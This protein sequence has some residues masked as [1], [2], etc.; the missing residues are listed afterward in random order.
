KLREEQRVLPVYKTDDVQNVMSFKPKTWYE[1]RLMVLILTLAD[2]GC[3][4]DEALSLKWDDVDFDNLLLTLHGKG[5]KDRKVPFS[6]ELRR[7]LF[8]FKQKHEHQR[9]FSTKRGEKW[10]QRNCYRDVKRLCTR[11]GIHAPERLLHSFRHTMASN[12]IRRGGSVAMLQRVLGHTTL[13]MTMR[14]VHIQTEDLSKNHERITL[15]GR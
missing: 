15:L 1:R 2:C 8:K 5:S 11:V 3:R 6:F 12:Y 10:G 7:H 9:V 4:I 13:Q 14:Y